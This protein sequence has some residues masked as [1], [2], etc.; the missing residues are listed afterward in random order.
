MTRKNK[1][2]DGVFTSVGRAVDENLTMAI[3][4]RSGKLTRPQFD[5]WYSKRRAEGAGMIV[6]LR[7][8]ASNMVQPLQAAVELG[9]ELILE[10]APRHAARRRRQAPRGSPR[11]RV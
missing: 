2:E 6:T 4:L 8:R 3:A 10:P 5:A 7:E 1:S 11:R 9:K